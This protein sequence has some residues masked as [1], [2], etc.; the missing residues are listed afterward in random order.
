VRYVQKYHGRLAAAVVRSFLLLTFVY[1]WL[2]EAAKWLAG[3]LL[4]G[5]HAKQD[6]RRQRMSAY[7]QVLRSGLQLQG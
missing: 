6:M 5:Q 7:G 4:P 2:E 1:Q 3:F